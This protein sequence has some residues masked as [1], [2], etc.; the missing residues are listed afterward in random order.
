METKFTFSP[1]PF[2]SKA[3]ANKEYIT[4]YNAWTLDMI[5]NHHCT[6]TIN[7]IC[8]RLKVSKTWIASRIYP[9]VEYVR[10]TPTRLEEL[11]MDKESTLLFN[12]LELRNYLMRAAIFTRQTKV[13]DLTNVLSSSQLAA[14]LENP[15]IQKWDTE[16]KHTYGKRSNRLLNSFDIAYDNV[17]ELKRTEYESVPVEAFD[18]WAISTLY[19]ST[20][21]K[22]KETAYREFFRKGMIKINIFGK[23]IFTQ[24]PKEDLSKIIYPMTVSAKEYRENP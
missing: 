4:A 19:F 8:K 13:I 10:I 6:V 24:H 17:N 14:A 23:A 16:N 9:A 22:N 11:N 18:F 21:Y 7:D 15:A 3:A 12:E 5:N 20:E 1:T 2:T